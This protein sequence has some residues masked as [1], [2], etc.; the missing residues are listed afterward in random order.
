MIRWRWMD[1]KR[2]HDIRE[3]EGQNSENWRRLIARTPSFHIIFFDFT[4]SSL[5]SSSPFP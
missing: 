4:T 3:R 2:D 1:G 5:I